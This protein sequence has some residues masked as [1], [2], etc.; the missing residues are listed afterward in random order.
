MKYGASAAST[1]QRLLQFEPYL[2][3]HGIEIETSQLLAD[4]HITRLAKGRRS[5]PV[6]IAASYLKRLGVLLRSRSYDLIWVHYE[7]FPY[8]PSAF[9]RLVA[10]SGQPIVYDCD[11]AIFHTYD[12][13]PNAVVRWFLRNKLAPLLRSASICLCGNAYLEAYASQ[14]CDETIVVPTV[15]DTSAYRPRPKDT[16]RAP[17]VGWIGSPSTWKYVEPLLPTILPLIA[18]RGGR[19][20]AI[21]TGPGGRGY[22]GIEVVDWSEET[23]IAEVQ[24]FDVGIMPLPDERWARGKC[25]YKL[26]QYM[27]CGLPVVGSPVGVN[28]EII[29]HGLNGFLA[30]DLGEWEQSLN[31]LLTDPALR[32]TM[33]SLG[34]ARAVER[35]SLASQEPRVLSALTRAASR[36]RAQSGAA[37][38]NPGQ[39]S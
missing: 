21:G 37:A 26:I 23:E 11:D 20:R 32:E 39:V 31:K 6:A 1:R 19:F 12:V 17:V 33:G 24:A 29:D 10:L 35:Y 3:K 16:S 13:H 2:R 34:R 5:N 7:T 4:E 38:R 22:P 25:G 14:Y 15:V 18:A 8:L 27:A 36:S 9:E 28:T 30:S